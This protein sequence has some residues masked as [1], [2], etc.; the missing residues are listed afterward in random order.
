MRLGLVLGAGTD[1]IGRAGVRALAAAGMRIAIHHRNEPA[2]AAALAAE[3]GDGPVLAGDFTDPAA[4]RQVVRDALALL[5][6]LDVMV[7]CCA[8]LL[9]RPLLETTDADWRMVHDINLAAAFAAGQEAARH[10]V[11]Q[12]AGRIIFI[13]S[14]NEFAPNPGLAAYAASKGGLRML[15]RVMALELAA[16]GIT[17]NLVAPG[18]I[19]TDLNRSA[20]ADPAWRAAK[21]ALIPSRR[22]GTPGDIGGIVAF[23]A[24][25]AA[26]YI[27]GTT[28]VADGGLALG[29]QP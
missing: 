11:H 20:L 25:D 19:E 16:H 21:Q 26:S 29:V 14:V 5:G 1:G 9:R 13:S 8:T 4:A 27:T 15:A 18:T 2:A 12:G 7:F 24:S 17:V 28:L 22:I 6:G 10:M 23:L 3:T